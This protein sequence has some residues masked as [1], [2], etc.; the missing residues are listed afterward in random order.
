[1]SN[2]SFAPTALAVIALLVSFAASPAVAQSGQYIYTVGFECG[3][4]ASADGNF[5]YE[6]VAKIA[7]YAIKV[8]LFNYGANS[9]NLTAQVHNTGPTRWPTSVPPITVAPSTVNAGHGGLLDCVNIVTAILGQTPTGKPFYSGILTVRSPTPLIVWATKTT[10]VCSGLATYYNGDFVDPLVYID[11]N[12]IPSTPS[13]GPLPPARISLFNCPT[14]N[15]PPGSPSEGQGPYTGPGGGVPPNIRPIGMMTNLQGN[16][17]V[18]NLGVSHSLDFERIEG[19]FV[20][21]DPA[22]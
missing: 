19:V 20:P 16:H 18:S 17:F 5:G 2:R 1:M 11:E 8:D 13:T 22:P 21:E 14:G 9:A 7:N 15:A 12:G 10:E 3:F 6:P 4:Q